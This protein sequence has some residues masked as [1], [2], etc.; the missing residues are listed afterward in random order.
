MKANKILAMA[1]FAATTIL[2]ASCAKDN[3]GNGTDPEPGTPA[4]MGISISLPTNNISRATNA[5]ANANY[6]DMNIESVRVFV[7][8]PDG[9]KATGNDTPLNFGADF[10]RVAET[11]TW[12]LNDDKLIQTS[13]GD[14]K[15]Y[16]G[17]NLPSSLGAVVSES[18]LTD[19]TLT[20]T[21][22]FA[23][24]ATS[25]EDDPGQGP[26]MM[27]TLY[28]KTVVEESDNN[29]LVEA[30][31]HRMMAK[32][33]VIFRDGFSPNPTGTPVTFTVTPDQ[34]TIGNYSG[35]TYTLQRT[36]AAGQLITWGD[37]N[38]VTKANQSK[39][40]SVTANNLTD[41][42]YRAVNA[43][44]TAAVYRT[45]LYMPE[46]STS[47]KYMRNEGTAAIIRGEL[48]PKFWTT[49]VDGVITETAIAGNPTYSGAEVYVAKYQGKFYFFDND[50]QLESF[51]NKLSL[52]NTAVDT[53][54][55]SG[56]K[57]YTYYWVFFNKD[58]K[59]PLTDI[60]KMEV[61]RNNYYEIVVNSIVTIGQ[62]GDPGKPL[63]PPVDDEKD[64]PVY[65]TTANLDIK[66][67]VAPWTVVTAGADL[68]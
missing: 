1:A 53:Y 15:V 43:N 41:F 39:S 16:V 36:N 14:K 64:D 45:G 67:N 49:V 29:N 54:E 10:S 52:P 58:P 47:T 66:I 40:T 13:V 35:F 18:Q 9:S 65:E 25:T 30:T 5:D 51:T 60:N 20:A 46:H 28:T 7:F 63:D 50:T 24:V 19:G 57:L 38:G 44:G 21:E 68:E 33:T 12:T 55:V 4:K 48:T 11:D 17:I 56:G 2:A 3:G 42:Q 37:I 8:E 23:N 27:S 22:L 26:A 59:A 32:A 62:P 31:V 61:A 6:Q 34:Y